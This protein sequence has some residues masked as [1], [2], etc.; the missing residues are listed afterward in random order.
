MCVERRGLFVFVLACVAIAG[1]SSGGGT[2]VQSSVLP[3]PAVQSAAAPAL[4][5]RDKNVKCIRHVVI[6]I[7]E[8]RTLNNLFMG[9]PGAVTTTSGKAGGAS[10][11]L[12]E[13]TLE[14]GK[15]DISHCWQDA[16]AAY[17]Y[18]R[19]DG[20]YQL[21]RERLTFA[22][23][24]SLRPPIG[25]GDLGP[26][27]YVPHDAPAYKDE[28]GPYW[29]MAQQYVLADHFFATDFGPSFTAHQNLIAGTV[30]IANNL[31]IVN[32]PGTFVPATGGMSFSAGPWG[33]DSPYNT[34]TSTINIEDDILEGTGPFPCFTEYKTLADTL[35]ARGISWQYYT[36]TQAPN[37]E[38]Y[39][40]GVYL[41]NP[42]AAIRRVRYGPDW[43]NIIEP[44]SKVLEVAKEGK[45]K[46]VTWVVP[47]G[48]D[49]DH[50]GRF[51]TDRG[52]SWVAAVVNAI[53]TG[54]QWSSTAI[55]VL[56]DDW[57][58]YYDPVRP[59]H[60]DF[61]GLGFRVPCIIISP[62]ARKSYVSHTEYEF[63]SVLKFVE[64]VFSLPPLGASNYGYGYTDGRANSLT[65][66]FNFTQA[67]RAFVPIP[68]K[69]PP[70]EF[71][72]EKPSGVPPDS[73]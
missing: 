8:N 69:Y 48:P 56:W 67:P 64:E 68:A 15:W 14:G 63:G 26:Y 6:I 55:V 65:D 45:L 52:P 21:P 4:C 2:T 50:P 9:F 25:T 16:V 58:G 31:S 30:E 66:S 35:D 18:G 33:C 1:C 39:A 24:P 51:A 27:S 72:N 17:D 70:S 5:R 61:R 40:P 71:I 28:A 59:P 20:F 10:V 29:K 44:Q 19:M 54:P 3:Q 23:C 57:G 43:A 13:Q 36:P 73:E 34:V 46:A 38:G 49:S 62:Y 12:L 53:G 37:P 22:Q 60:R 41:W 47:T 7:Q 42:F 11:P 32:Y